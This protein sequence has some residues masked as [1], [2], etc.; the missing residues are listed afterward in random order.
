M[1]TWNVIYFHAAATAHYL[2]LNKRCIKMKCAFIEPSAA[3]DLAATASA[4]KLFVSWNAP[5]GE[6]ITGYTVELKN[7]SDSQKLITATTTTF[8]NLTP[9]QKYT[10]VVVTMIDTLRGQSVEKDFYTSKS[11]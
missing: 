7:V 11:S 9:G 3:T 1:R 5:S 2:F 10:V 4:G 6:E 8:D